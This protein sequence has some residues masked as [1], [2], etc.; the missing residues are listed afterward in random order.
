LNH[1]PITRPRLQLRTHPFVPVLRTQWDEINVAYQ[2]TSVLNLNSLDTIGK[3]KRKE[4]YEAQLAQIERDIEKLS[5]KV[6]Y[7]MLDN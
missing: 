3:V 6:V 7:V 5:K 4:Q 2:K 1:Q